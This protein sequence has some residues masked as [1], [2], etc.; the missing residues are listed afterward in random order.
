M[1]NFTETR[2]DTTQNTRNFHPNPCEC[3]TNI[4]KA[5][6]VTQDWEITHH[7]YFFRVTMKLTK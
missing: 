5:K 7:F 2:Y 1:A 4:Y 3:H 6:P